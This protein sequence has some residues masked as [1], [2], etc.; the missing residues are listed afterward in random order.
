MKKVIRKKH[1]IG[2]IG[3]MQLSESVSGGAVELDESDIEY[4]LQSTYGTSLDRLATRH[5]DPETKVVGGD[6]KTIALMHQTAPQQT[7][8]VLM[9]KYNSE[10]IRSVLNFL[11]LHFEIVEVEDT[12][13]NRIVITCTNP[14]R[15]PPYK[16]IYKG[17]KRGEALTSDLDIPLEPETDLVQSVLDIVD[18]DNDEQDLELKNKEIKEKKEKK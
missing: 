1:N 17:L 9:K 12:A 10:Q 2:K 13:V 14:I 5:L 4:F 16:K 6:V 11:K 3:N 8:T 18:F 15:T 7:L